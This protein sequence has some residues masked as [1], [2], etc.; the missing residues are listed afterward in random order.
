MQQNA[1][2]DKPYPFKHGSQCDRIVQRIFNRLL[3][4][5]KGAE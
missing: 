5:I 4:L 3:E 2:K 1:Q